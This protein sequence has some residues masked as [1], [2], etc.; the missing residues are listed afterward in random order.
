MLPVLNEEDILDASLRSVIEFF[1]QNSMRNWRLA[2]V[3]NGS[4]DATGDISKRLVAE[5]GTNKVRYMRLEERGV[6]LA[7]RA[8]WEN[9]TADVV[10]YMDIDLATNLRHLLDVKEKFEVYAASVVNG[11]RL[12]PNSNVVDR[13]VL[14]T[15]TSRALNL[16]MKST[17]NNNF[18][19]AMCGFKFFNRLVALE[20]LKDIP[21]MPD[22][23]VS[24]EML[25]RA[26]WKGLCIEEIAVEWNDD[27]NSK[28]KIL[29]LT[30]QYLGHIIRLRR[31]KQCNIAKVT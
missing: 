24:A 28:A 20:I 16:L 22:W 5:F 17:L 29:S 1:S 23:F 30:R 15:T 7:I 21:R 10:G 4:L 9:S 31:E 13:T 6:G 18:T 12:L 19:D 14:R 26:E 25:V 11:S 27:Q 3:D 2:I 8:G